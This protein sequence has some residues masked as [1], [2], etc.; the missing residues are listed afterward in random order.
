MAVAEKSALIPAVTLNDGKEE[1][2]FPEVEPLPPPKPSKPK[3]KIGA[4]RQRFINISM[5]VMTKLAMGENPFVYNYTLEDFENGKVPEFD[6][7]AE[8]QKERDKKEKANAKSTQGNKSKKKG[9]GHVAWGKTKP[10]NNQFVRDKD[11]KLRRTTVAPIKVPKKPMKKGGG[12]KF[13]S[14]VRLARFRKMSSAKG[15][16]GQTKEEEEEKLEEIIELPKN[17][18]FCAT[19]SAEAQY[20]MLKGYEDVLLNT[21]NTFYTDRQVSL[22]RVKTPHKP[23]N[24]LYLAEDEKK[25]PAI[26]DN[27]TWNTSL[28]TPTPTNGVSSSQAVPSYQLP[29]I[30]PSTGLHRTAS[31]VGKLSS[32]QNYLK[33]DNKRVPK[34]K[35]LKLT[36]R[37]EK[38]QDILDTVRLSQG[39]L[40]TSPR[41]TKFIPENNLPKKKDSPLDNYNAWSHAWAKEFKLQYGM[42]SH[43]SSGISKGR[44]AT[45]K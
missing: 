28:P 25:E 16:D 15:T 35:Q 7:R 37:F 12:N 45:I 11:G 23:V 21:F 42:G 14:L 20:A 2:E 27:E 10:L 33:V 44:F 6:K 32:G 31:L 3:P 36:L 41:A 30:P 24:C 17:P 8:D 18:R 43:G 40:V 5:G 39:D 38:A 26:E 13:A 34:E 1:L 22:F 9:T 19:L 4:A 29:G